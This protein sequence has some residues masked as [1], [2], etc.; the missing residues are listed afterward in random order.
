MT[1]GF[2]SDSWALAIRFEPFL[3]KFGNQLHRGS[4]AMTTQTYATL[5]FLILSPHFEQRRMVWTCASSCGTFFLGKTFILFCVQL[6]HQ[7]DAYMYPTILHSTA[8]PVKC[9]TDGSHGKFVIKYDK[10]CCR[11]IECV[12]FGNNLSV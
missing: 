11:S 1:S 6:T 3:L 4:L 9:V 8:I 7:F 12:C 10:I 2:R 5:D